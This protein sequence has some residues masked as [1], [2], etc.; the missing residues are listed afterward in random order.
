MA[1][2]VGGTSNIAALRRSWVRLRVLE[3]G[4][5]LKVMLAMKLES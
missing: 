4:S 3:V 2:K 1:N 5:N